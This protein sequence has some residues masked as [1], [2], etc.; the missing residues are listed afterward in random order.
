MV[1]A[2][3]RDTLAGLAV[4]ATNAKQD[5]KKIAQLAL[6]PKRRWRV[7][8]HMEQ[9]DSHSRLRPTAIDPAHIRLKLKQKLRFIDP[10]PSVIDTSRTCPGMNWSSR[11]S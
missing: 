7:V 8:L 1:A 5:E 9:H 10:A 4:A 11:L 3:V 6:R 2:K